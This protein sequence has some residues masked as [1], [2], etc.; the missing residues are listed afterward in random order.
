MNRILLISGALFG[1]LTVI[2]GAF[3]AHAFQDILIENE[4]VD[5]FETGVKYQAM[6]SLLLIIMGMLADKINNRKIIYAGY[7][8]IAGIIVFSGSL[9]ILSLTNL[10]FLGAITPL[11]GL[12]F[13]IGWIMLLYSFWKMKE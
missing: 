13:I 11:G 2:I 12:L 7:S 10:T 8:I 1:L 4:R 9:Y 3:G 6:H 5:T